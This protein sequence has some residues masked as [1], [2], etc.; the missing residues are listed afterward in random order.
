VTLWLGPAVF[1]VILDSCVLYPYE[2]RCLLLEA[3]QEGLY[4]VHWSRRILNDTVRNLVEDGRIDPARAQRLCGVM[5]AAFPE[6]LVDPPPE[7]ELGLSCDPGDRHVLAATV[8]AK[9]EVIVT[10]N[11]R[12]FPITAT[13]PFGV[14]ALTPDQFLCNLLDLAPAAI[15]GCLTAMERQQRN[16][17]R[18]V[19]TLLQ[20]LRRE[21]PNFASRGLEF[22]SPSS[23]TPSP[24]QPT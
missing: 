4:R 9:A 11:I 15:H 22:L 2:L 18:T 20:I 1:P 7:L 24:D 8:A 19:E 12:H 10:R 16:P 17:S 14:E 13:E 5:A 23:A 3:A 6:A 21:A